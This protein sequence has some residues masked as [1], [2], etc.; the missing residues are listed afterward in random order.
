VLEPSEGGLGRQDAPN[1]FPVSRCNAYR[2]GANTVF[3]DVHTNCETCPSLPPLRPATTTTVIV[4]PPP[5]RDEM[6]TATDELVISPRPSPT[7]SLQSA[8]EMATPR[9]RQ[10]TGIQA[11]VGTS[12]GTRSLFPRSPLAPHPRAELLRAWPANAVRS[13]TVGGRPGPPPPSK[14]FTLV[15]HNCLASRDVFLSLFGSFTQL[16]QSRSIVVLQDYPVYRG[17]LPSF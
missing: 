7:C 5:C 9:A 6:D 13:C 15:H 12:Q 17:K 14:P 11:P 3:A 10:K 1:G 2:S 4:P 16:A 8:F